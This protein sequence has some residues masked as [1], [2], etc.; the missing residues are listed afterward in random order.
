MGS[1]TYYREAFLEDPNAGYR[2]RI[3]NNGEGMLEFD[4]QELKPGADGAQW[5]SLP[6]HGMPAGE[7]DAICRAIQDVKDSP[8]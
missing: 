5:V 7:A 8:V 4:Y 6:F 1:L 3:W 2:W